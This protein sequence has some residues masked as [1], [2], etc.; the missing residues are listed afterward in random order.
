[1][2][3]IILIGRKFPTVCRKT[4]AI[5]CFFLDYFLPQSDTDCNCRQEM[6]TTPHNN[7]ENSELPCIIIIIIM[8]PLCAGKIQ[9]FLQA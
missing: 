5:S 8:R 6:F 3:L 2:P 9:R 1:V 4:A 7:A